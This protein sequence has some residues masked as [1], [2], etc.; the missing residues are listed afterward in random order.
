MGFFTKKM[1]EK[2]YKIT[3]VGRSI[4]TAYDLDGNTCILKEGMSCLTKINPKLSKII[5]EE[6]IED[7]KKSVEKT[8]QIIVK[9][10]KKMVK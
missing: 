2:K 8:E 4:I 3:N 9:K 6:M 10:E 5:V 7:T 1:I